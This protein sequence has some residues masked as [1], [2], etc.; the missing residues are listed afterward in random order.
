M[1]GWEG[2]DGGNSFVVLFA[3]L[4]N[5]TQNITKAITI[6][7]RQTRAN[8]YYSLLFLNKIIRVRIENVAN[9]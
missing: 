2:G 8:G 4:M 3:C 6:M 5:I 1:V 9:R 7:W